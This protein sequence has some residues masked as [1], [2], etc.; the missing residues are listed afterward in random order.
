MHGKFVGKVRGDFPPE[1]FS[2]ILSPPTFGGKFPPELF[3]TSDN[4]VDGCYFAW[5][6]SLR[7]RRCCLGFGRR[8]PTHRFH[9]TVASWDTTPL[10]H[11]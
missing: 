10:D 1:N 2:K 11:P 9:R 7:R 8:A 5:K 4:P 3:E 6:F